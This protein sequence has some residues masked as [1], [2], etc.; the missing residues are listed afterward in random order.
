MSARARRA[1]SS[2]CRPELP[3]PAF[4]KIVVLTPD[5]E[6]REASEAAAA[7][8]GGRG[9]RARGLC[10]R[11]PA[12][13]RSALA[14]SRSSSGSWDPIP[15]NSTRISEKALDIMRGDPRRAA[16]EPRLGQSHARAPLRP[17]PGS[18]EPDRPVA[19]GG[20]R[21]NSSSCSPASPSRRSARTSAMSPSWHAAPAA[22]G[23]IRRVWRISR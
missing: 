9:T 7:A 6:A 20:G 17:G 12:R 3:D 14:S 23:S 10:A 5:A 2:R 15:R 21:S 19:G 16:G 13:L 11:H 4:A 1:S 18:A 22:S 8:G